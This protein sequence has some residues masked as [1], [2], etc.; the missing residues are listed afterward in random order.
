MGCE[1]AHNAIPACAKVPVRTH[2]FGKND[3]VKIRN[4]FRV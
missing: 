3:L 1:G 2:V 4:T